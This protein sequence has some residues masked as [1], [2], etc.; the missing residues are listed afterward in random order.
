MDC[1]FFV[2]P[3]LDSESV[4]IFW[5]E[6]VKSLVLNCTTYTS[7][8]TNECFSL[9]LEILNC[10]HN[11]VAIFGGKIH[12]S[13][14]NEFGSVQLIFDK[15]VELDKPMN[16]TISVSSTMKILE[17]VE[18]INRLENI[19]TENSIL[20][21]KNDSTPQKFANPEILFV[22]DFIKSGNS[23]R[24]LARNLF[25]NDAII[26]D[27]DG[28]SDSLRAKTRRIIAQGKEFVNASVFD[29]F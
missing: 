11:S 17:Q 15:K 4:S 12:L 18:A 24:E 21:E 3:K 19:L 6:S 28:I 23:Q 5:A 25:G 14:S 26:N 1:Y 13:I 9:E 20:I 16:F 27:W 29:F 10:K 22:Y 8:N 2:D 7:K